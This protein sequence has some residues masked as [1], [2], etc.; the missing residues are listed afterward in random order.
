M[1]HHVV[2]WLQWY[3]QEVQHQVPV[4]DLKLDLVVGTLAMV[5][6]VGEAAMAALSDVILLG[7]RQQWEFHPLLVGGQ[8]GRRKVLV[9]GMAG[10]DL[11]LAIMKEGDRPDLLVEVV[12]GTAHKE[13][14]VLAPMAGEMMVIPTDDLLHH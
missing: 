7:I 4:E 13:D 12:P 11:E 8:L 14:T 1:L 5:G 9:D 10:Q 6:I 3:H 2:L